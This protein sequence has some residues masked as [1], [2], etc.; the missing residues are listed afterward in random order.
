M[1]DLYL[2]IL[3]FFSFG[4][5][6]D[7]LLY[8]GGWVVVFCQ[9]RGSVVFGEGENRVLDFNRLLGGHHTF[10]FHTALVG[11]NHKIKVILWIA[12]CGM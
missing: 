11:L 4:I 5:E 3:C 6:L 8:Q 9:D 7:V 2:Y 12:W 10:P 1:T